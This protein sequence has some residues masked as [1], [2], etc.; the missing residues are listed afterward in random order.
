MA[1]DA[2]IR[3][4]DSDPNRAL[5]TGTFSNHL[6]HPDLILVG[7][8]ER[9]ATAVITIFLH[10]ARHDLDRLAGRLRPLQRDIDQAA[11]VHDSGRIHQLAPAPKRAFRY[12]Q[13][14]L[15]HVAYH[16]VGPFHLGYPP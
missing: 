10:Q 1:G 4:T 15:V 9:L 13:L 7:D 11:V 2:I 8:R 5:V 3:N 6:H 14:M 16:R 12:R